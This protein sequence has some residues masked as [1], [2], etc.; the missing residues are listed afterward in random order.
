L[1]NEIT[2][3]IAIALDSA[4]NRAEAARP[5]D[6]PDAL[7]Y[8]FRARAVFSRP[9]TPENYA[10]AINL[11]ERALALDPNSV[12]AQSRLASVLMSR[13]FAGMSSTASADITRAEGLVAQALAISPSSLLAH[14]AKGQVLRAQNRYDESIRE[15]EMVLASNHNAVSV[16][17][18][19]AQSK[20]NIGSIDEALPLVEQAIR[21]SPRDGA[22]GFWYTQIGR[23]H[24]LLSRTDE[25]ILALEKARSAS[26][27]HPAVRAYLASS[28][29]LKGEAERA[30]TE[31]DEA[32]RLSGDDRYSSITRLRAIGNFGV[33]KVRAL[34]EATYFVGLR[35]AGMTEE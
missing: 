20:F 4:L 22:L 25:A 5:T 8:I 30:A 3:R 28:Y 24:L 10:E 27:A 13:V 23:T 29:G 17:A 14:T 12:G 1:Q 11:F 32:R 7:D 35:K 31:L 18:N 6:N 33:P 21:L 16:L 19:L 9:S 34:Y 26:P 2:S 15:Y